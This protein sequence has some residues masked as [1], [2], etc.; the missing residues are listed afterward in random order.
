MGWS[1]WKTFGSEP[2]KHPEI[3][4][5]SNYGTV[6]IPHPK[7]A[8]L[9]TSAQPIYYAPIVIVNKTIL[10]QNSTTESVMGMGFNYDATTDTLTLTNV[11]IGG[12]Q[13]ELYYVN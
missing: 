12:R 9:Y 7:M 11:D 13:F 6:S 2:Q 10:L 8:I 4:T 5:S 1:E 3:L